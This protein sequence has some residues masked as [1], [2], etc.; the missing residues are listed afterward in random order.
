[1]EA[2]LLA[3]KAKRDDYLLEYEKVIKQ[4]WLDKLTCDYIRDKVIDA[5]V[6]ESG[7]CAILHDEDPY[8]TNLP[9]HV[10]F[11]GGVDSISDQ[12]LARV[13]GD[14]IEIWCIHEN[15]LKNR[16]FHIKACYSKPCKCTI[17]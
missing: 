17:L 11:N 8:Y 16:Y 13:D 9:Y 6:L 3:S 14:P 1:M 4:N 7:G 12:L 10:W 15:R 2:L 5:E